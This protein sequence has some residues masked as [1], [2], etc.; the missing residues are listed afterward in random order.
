[1]PPR[2]ALLHGWAFGPSVWDSLVPLLPASARAQRWALPGYGAAGDRADPLVIDEQWPASE[3]TVCLGWSLGGMLLT[4]L[5]ALQ[6]PQLRA[7]ILIGVNLRF[8]STADWP[9]GVEPAEMQSLEDELRAAP[10]AALKRFA[11]LCAR[12]PQAARQTLRT[13]V[14]CLDTQPPPPL[15]VLQHGLAQLQ[16]LD[17]RAVIAKLSAPTL[18]IVGD[19]D[20]L[21]PIAAARAMQS[22]N[23]AI[24]LKVIAGA[25]HAPFLSHPNEV[26][27]AIEPFLQ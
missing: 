23:A 9:Y 22:L 8:L 7:L 1:M 27:Q 12:A 4:S 14:A 5:A 16:T 15:P 13:L 3:P 21:V 19:A 24:E 20:P 10:A 17:L 18:L 26:I 25:G 2:L 11:L 6:P